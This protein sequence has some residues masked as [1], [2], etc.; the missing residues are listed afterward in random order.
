[1][2]FWTAIVLIIGI[3]ALSEMYRAR[4]KTSSE[5]YDKLFNDLTDRLSRL[6]ERMVNIETIVLEKEKYRKFEELENQ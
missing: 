5:K 6:E 4:L 2:S 1:M 3:G